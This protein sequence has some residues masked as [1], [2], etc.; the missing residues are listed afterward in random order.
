[1]ADGRW[2]EATST[3]TVYG[4][5]TAAAQRT[6]LLNG[7]IGPDPGSPPDVSELNPSGNGD[8]CDYRKRR[9][10]STGRGRVCTTPQNLRPDVPRANMWTVC[11]VRAVRP[12]PWVQLGTL[13]TLTDNVLPTPP[14]SRDGTSRGRSLLGSRFF[15]ETFIFQP[16]LVNRRPNYGLR[17]CYVGDSSYRTYQFRSTQKRDFSG[18]P[19]V[20]RP[21]V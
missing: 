11:R 6:P 2:P 15:N 18:V 3:F 7:G 5:T 4:G 21:V 16:L 12:V 19:D 10:S 8:L 1:M 14:F 17:L 9:L 13:G 20:P